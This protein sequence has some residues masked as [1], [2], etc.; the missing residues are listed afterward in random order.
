MKLTIKTKLIA[1]FAVMIA[2]MGMSSFLALKSAS[3]LAGEIDKIADETAFQLDQSLEMKA[4]AA[5][6]MSLIKSYLAQPDADRAAEIAQAVDVRFAAVEDAAAA[7]ENILFTDTSKALMADFRAEWNNFL[8]IEA[9]LRE[10]GLANTNRRASEIYESESSPAYDALVEA[11]EAL[12][13]LRDRPQSSVVDHQTFTLQAEIGGFLE[14]VHHI[15]DDE[16]DMLIYHGE[17]ERQSSFDEIGEGRAT[18]LRHLAAAED[19]AT[20]GDARAVAELRTLFERWIGAV[21]RVADLALQNTNRISNLMLNEQLEPAFK[22]S[23][24][25][26][27]AMALRSK[28]VLELAQADAHAVYASVR[29]MLLG[30]GIGAAV[31]GIVAALWLSMSI[32]RGLNRATGLVREVSSGNLEVDVKSDSRDEIGL[33]LGDIARMVERLKSVVGDVTTAA[34]SVASGSEELTST[35]AQLSQGAQEQASSTEETSASVEQMAANIKQNAENTAQT[36]SIARQAA[37]D[38][39]TSGEAVGDAVKAMETIA[40][41]IMVVQEIARQTDLLALN[42]AVEAARAGEHG[43]GFAVVASEVRK[44]AE[45]SQEAATEI[46]GLSGETLRSAQSAGEQLKSLVP[47]IQKTSELVAEIA[48]ANSELN[49]GA[50]Q[51]SEAIQQLDTVTQQNT[52]AS[53]EMSSAASELSHQAERLQSSISFFKVDGAGE[54][55]G[56]LR[57]AT[58]G[59]PGSA[60][61]RPET[62]GKQ[63]GGF[64]FDLGGGE[65]ALDAEFER[66]SH[67]NER[68]A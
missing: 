66:V 10:Y 37:K 55:H 45:R 27:D 53:E 12:V 36:E 34:R 28:E 48:A 40:D 14:H 5:R 61:V 32:G 23:F 56:D 11:A 50:S 38:A 60:A 20:G 44:L 59:Q 62:R 58:S 67:G 57:T 26:A 49:A 68:A 35:S 33:L 17:E 25:A 1:V 13:D 6:S 2:L 9:E 18:A 65:D 8:E 22:Q 16:L 46:S 19:A 54:V 42:A 21:E 64:A 47:D 43:R 63:E 7:I 15:H 39:E 3:Q 41:K 52:S 30:L 4:A 29:N 24:N 31:I 51:I